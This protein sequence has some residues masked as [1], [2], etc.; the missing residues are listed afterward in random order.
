MESVQQQSYPVTET[1]SITHASRPSNAS[2]PKVLFVLAISALGGL[3]LGVGAAVLREL[4]DRA[5]RTTDQLENTL[6]L[7]CLAV[8]PVIKEPAVSS[9]HSERTTRSRSR[10]IERTHT[11][12]WMTVEEPF[13]RFTE[14][15]RSI[16]VAMDLEGLTKGNKVIGLT[17]TLPNEGKS[18]VAANLAQLIAHAGQNVILI[19]GD[20][21]NPSLTRSLAPTARAGLMELV[22][23]KSQLADSVWT[24]SSTDM[25]FIPVKLKRR[26]QHTNEF[27]ASD[28][29]KKFIEQLRQSYDYVI[30]DLP[31]LAPVVDVRSS[32]HLMDALIFVVEWGV[33]KVDVITHSLRQSQAIHERV[34]GAVLNKVDMAALRRFETNRDDYYSEKYYSRYGIKD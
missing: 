2:H 1:R 17:S 16:K 13:S 14:G 32:A 6:G 22:S 29:M 18:T 19:D 23:E 5:I 24:D 31:P 10:R 3:A 34:V 25:H 8:L 21:R 30:V 4:L 26:V 15:I 33:T 28:A 20:L 7:Q 11:P 9:G 12:L 27:M